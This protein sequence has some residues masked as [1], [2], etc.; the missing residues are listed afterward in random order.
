MKKTITVA[1]TELRRDIVG[2]IN[3]SGLPPAIS[4]MILSEISMAVNNAAQEQYR[5]DLETPE[6]EPEK[7]E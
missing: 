7:E 3:D 2:L 1:I 5:K 4:G 6:E